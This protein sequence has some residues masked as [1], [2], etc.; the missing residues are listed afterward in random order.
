MNTRDR[1]VWALSLKN[2]M[3]VIC[4]TVLAIYFGKWWII[5][6]SCLFYS[7]LEVAKEP[8]QDN[9]SNETFNGG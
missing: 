3:V 9:G 8:K 6:F 7:S 2:S 5:L 1:M 4:F